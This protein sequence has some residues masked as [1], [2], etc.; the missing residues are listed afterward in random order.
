M[1]RNDSETKQQPSESRARR[2][3]HKSILFR[4]T[5]L[6][7]MI[8]SFTLIFFVASIVP[9]Q[10]KEAIER[11]KSEANSI[12]A[13]ISQV[14]AN[15][16]VLEDYSFAVDH[17][18]KVVSQSPSILYVVITKHD[19][20]SLMHT[21][22]MW[23]MD[24]LGGMWTRQT[25][26]I[27][28]NPLTDLGEKKEAVF[29]YTQPFNYSGIDWGQI[30]LGM[31]LDQYNA[32]MKNIMFRTLF[33]ALISAALGLLASLIFARKLTNPILQLE[34]VTRDFASGNRSA[35]ADI[36]SNDELAS[37]AESFNIMTDA[38]QQA[39]EQLEQRVRE[40][41]AD[42]KE[43]NKAL[44]AEIGCRIEAEEKI[45]A[46]LKEKE[47]LLKE[48]H[49]RVK[50]N[51]QIIQSLLYLQSK[52]VKDPDLLQLFQDSQNRVKSMALIHERLYRSGDFANINFKDYIRSLT[53]HLLQTYQPEETRVAVKLDIND[54]SLSIDHGIPCGLIINELV[55][56]SLKYAFPDDRKGVIEI[57]MFSRN[58]HADSDYREY[59][60]NVKDDG[61]GMAKDYDNLR[62]ESLG[63][64]LVHN[65]VNQL[66][67]SIQFENSNGT[68]IRICFGCQSSLP[69]ESDKAAS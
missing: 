49:H 57:S 60:L 9:F 21:G 13:S 43:V 51:L 31:S 23:M 11:L 58:G 24:T 47:I 44:E 69:V 42:L 5:L 16:I 64:K 50:N 53:G 33:M 25:Q 65:L 55:S 7:W 17:C 61:V 18:M 20:F 22:T 28:D 27:I 45:K 35:R 67:G 62:S 26:G 36:H 52:H 6:S 34:K 3:W 41:T 12:A 29:H 37:L 10:K 2:P 19:G 1:L 14:T 56:N 48:I 46:S 8:I 38:L 4:T 32:Y 63:L 30:H 66:D 39:T 40:R 15:A 54:V 59:I 68:D